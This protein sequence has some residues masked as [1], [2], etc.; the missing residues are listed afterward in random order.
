MKAKTLIIISLLL[1]AAGLLSALELNLKTPSHYEITQRGNVI[2]EPGAPTLPYYGVR[3]LIPFGHNVQSVMATL[4]NPQPVSRNID[5]PM[6][7]Q[8]QPISMPAPDTTAPNP[9]IWEKSEFWPAQDYVYLGTQ[10]QRGY[11][12]AIIN[13]YP[14]KYNPQTRELKVYEDINLQIQH[15]HNDELSRYQANMLRKD[16]AAITELCEY[17]INPEVVD[18]Y[19]HS[20]RGRDYLPQS[21]LTRDNDPH[22]MIIV[23]HEDA[24]DW[25][26]DYAQWRTS[27]GVSTAVFSMQDI[28]A[29]YNGEDNAAKLRAFIQDV[30]LSWADSSDPLEYVILGGDDELVPERGAYG[31]VWQTIDNRMPTDI[32]FSNLDGNW[33]ANGNNI[34]G[35]PSDNVDM[36]PEVHIGRFPAETQAEFD[37]IFRKTRH[38]VENQTFSNNISVMF[39]ENLNWNPVT[40]GGDYK[41]DVAQYI[42]DG[43]QLITSYERDNTYDGTIVWNAINDGANVMNHMGHANETFLMGQ[44]N[45]TI[46]R[47]NN[48]EYGFLYTQGCYPAAFDQRTSGDGECIGETI[49]FVDGGVF[50]FIGNTRY[51]WYMPGSIDGASQFYDREYFIGLFETP[52]RELGKALTYSRVQ[53]LNAAL[54]HDVM[55]W[56]YYEVVLFGD[57]SI[58][59]K[60]PDESLPYLSLENYEITDEDGDN[61]GSLNPG[62]ALRIYPRIRNHE[63]WASAYDVEIS[64]TSLPDGIEQIS[65]SLF[66][67][68]LPAGG[69]SDEDAYISFQ[70]PVTLPFGIYEIELYVDAI[71]P[72]TQ[73]SVGARRFTVQFEITLID[74]R[75]PWDCQVGTRSAPIVYDFDGDGS[76][77]IMYLDVYGDAYILSKEGEQTGGFELDEEQNIMRSFA[78]GDINGDGI[79]ELVFTSRTGKVYATA[80]D[81]TPV[82]EYGIGSSFLFTPVLADIDGDGVN[83]I[84]AHSLDKK[85]YALK[86]D[87]S[88]VDGFPVTFGASLPSEMAAADIDGDG[89]MEI[90]L[91][92][93]S[94]ELHVIKGDGQN[95]TG[96]PVNLQR[97]ITGAPL[98]LENNRIA[99]GAGPYMVLVDTNGEILF[100]TET[101]TATQTGA[102]PADLTRDGNSE[103]VFTTMEGKLFAI[104][105]EG[106]ILPG[107]PVITGAIFNTPPLIADLDGDIYLEILLQSYMNSVYA[108]NHDGS[109][110]GGFPFCSDFNG[111][112]PSTL[113][114]LDNDGILRL[115][116]GYS[117]GILVVNLRR[118]VTIKMPWITY[119]GGLLRQGSYSSTGYVSSPD[120]TIIP[121]QDA[122]GQNYPN[123]FNP[124]TTISFSLSQAGPAKLAI[125]NLKGQLVRTL[126]D[127]RLDSGNHSAVWDGRDSQGSSVSSGMYLYR[128][129][130]AQG[131]HTQK[132][133]LLK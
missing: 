122:L 93:Q 123:P 44:G 14:Y 72:V 133:M 129:I 85:L 32:Y 12:V 75:F 40:W 22:K 69:V 83:E 97:S 66:I 94:G 50:A 80:L 114:D 18:S 1:L 43:Y 33:N 118:P 11:Q 111:N 6:A 60:L 131:N 101:G 119:R 63:D 45:N 39:G 3:V 27:Q 120:E 117:T 112:T 25:F 132:M 86:G 42:P 47:L 21:H 34:Y 74:N 113:V 53:N 16:A 2:L 30:Y 121:V 58:Q 9:L 15:S 107:F 57:P 31:K 90:I 130:T 20:S 59:A 115:V 8:Q 41:D 36:L 77:D 95:L 23:T 67:S 35:E 61:D 128:L 51:G 125:Y 29:T 48:T 82:F 98:V 73:L 56:C 64:L 81:G 84:I 88:L 78:M 127:G 87:G 38:Y 5:L 91:G 109:M 13:I 71:H 4:S 10:F 96:F 126:V 99:V 26:A 55:R 7:R 52:N 103:M 108:Y 70:L 28:Y 68:H 110:V 102:V 100:E 116:S 46:R 62:E 37:N 89:S 24:M 54:A 92:T 79:P 17:I 106:N 104:D 49:V 19:L 65:P 124:S 105:Q 76:L